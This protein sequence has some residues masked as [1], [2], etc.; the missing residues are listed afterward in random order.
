MQAFP[1]REGSPDPA[2]RRP[3]APGA[4]HLLPPRGA[5]PRPR[6]RPRAAGFPFSFFLLCV[7]MCACACVRVCEIWRLTDHR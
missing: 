2:G 7:R 3:L 6:A 5:Q 1:W 4:T